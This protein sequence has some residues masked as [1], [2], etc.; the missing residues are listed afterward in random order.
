MAKA[1]TTKTAQKLNDQAMQK[2]LYGCRVVVSRAKKQAGA[3]TSLLRDAGAEVSE[4]PFIEIRAPRSFK[5][6][7]DGLRLISEYEWLILSS[8]NGVDAMIDRMEKLG[9]SKRALMHLNIAAIGTATRAAL[10]NFGLRV[11]VMPKEYVAESL[12]EALAQRIK[13]KRVL[14]CRAKIARDLIPRELRRL[15]AYV[16]VADAYETIL[17]RSS[18]MRL[19]AA[20]ANEKKRP[21]IITF[22]SAST[23]QNYMNLLGI[24]SGSSKVIR[25]VRNASIGPVTSEELRKHGLSVDAQAEPYTIKGLVDAILKLAEE[26]KLER[27]EARIAAALK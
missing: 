8:V 19:R 15:G 6:L 14:L 9:I 17:P 7:N 26:K 20:L 5:P 11:T 3:L 24:R 4:I 27:A 2:P 1:R 25:G 13:G 22:T 23:V 18:R 12:V 21:H 16:D 10:E